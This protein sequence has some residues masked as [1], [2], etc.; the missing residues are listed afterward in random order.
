M[1]KEKAGISSQLNSA[2]SARDQKTKISL[3]ESTGLQL[4]YSCK[5]RITQRQSK[6]SFWEM[7]VF[8]LTIINNST[9]S[10]IFHTPS[11]VQTQSHCEPSTRARRWLL[12]K[13]YKTEFSFLCTASP[14]DNSGSSVSFSQKNS[15]Y[16]VTFV[17]HNV[18]MFEDTKGDWLSCITQLDFF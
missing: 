13:W 11:M 10:V 9:Y 3:H 12:W 16:Y 5:S 14:W 7:N 17:R 6:V 2:Y 1:T 15:D 8:Y 4:W 18:L